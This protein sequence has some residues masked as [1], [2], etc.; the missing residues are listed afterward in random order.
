MVLLSLTRQ[1]TRPLKRLLCRTRQSGAPRENARGPQEPP[2]LVSGPCATCLCPCQA[3]FPRGT[4]FGSGSS[5]STPGHS[6]PRRVPSCCRGCHSAATGSPGRTPCSQPAA[7]RRAAPRPPGCHQLL[8]H[9]PCPGPHR[10]PELYCF[11]PSTEPRRAPINNFKR[12]PIFLKP[13]E[14]MEI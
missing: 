4:R 11:S 10:D 9:P 6:S 14:I 12:S 3:T 2:F 13:Q 8:P 5:P 7:A 1:P